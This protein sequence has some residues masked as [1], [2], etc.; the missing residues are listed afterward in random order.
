[1]K[2]I[3]SV[4]IDDIL[5]KNDKRVSEPM[6]G[7]MVYDHKTAG[8]LMMVPKSQ[9]KS[10]KKMMDRKGQSSILRKVTPNGG[11]LV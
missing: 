8:S 11:R 10:F 4:N 3:N 1:M 6:F 5:G 7:I 9:F 2:V